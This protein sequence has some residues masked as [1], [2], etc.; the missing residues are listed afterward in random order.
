[1]TKVYAFEFLDCIY[2]GSFSIVSLHEAKR[3]AF[4]E[5]VRWVNK[6]CQDEQHRMGRGW[7]P[8]EMK[9]WRV[10]EIELKE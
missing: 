8:L 5:M 3:T 10:R 9:R 7:K 6:E 4:K 1:M 2:E